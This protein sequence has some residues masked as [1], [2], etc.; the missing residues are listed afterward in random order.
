MARGSHACACHWLLGMSCL[1]AT[2]TG[3]ESDRDRERESRERTPSLPC[4]VVSGTH[5]I[6]FGIAGNLPDRELTT[7]EASYGFPT[8]TLHPSFSLLVFSLFSLSRAKWA[9]CQSHLQPR[10]TTTFFFLSNEMT[11]Q[12]IYICRNRCCNRF[13]CSRPKPC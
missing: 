13:D 6:L 8:E 10:G 2:L 12:Q 7:S 9:Q 5:S 1:A 11:K 3:R 4:P